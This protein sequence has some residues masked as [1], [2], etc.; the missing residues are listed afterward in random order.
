MFGS[1]PHETRICELADGR[2]LFHAAGRAYYLE[3]HAH[4]ER[5]ERQLR[6][7]VNASTLAVLA[8]FVA[9][10]WVENWWLGLFALPAFLLAVL[11]E[12][13][14]VRGLEEATDPVVRH[15]VAA[16]S[17][18]TKE[19]LGKHHFWAAVGLFF[20]VVAAVLRKRPGTPMQLLEMAVLGV[21]VAIA[22]GHLW[23]H[24]RLR[25]ER[26]II[27][28]PGRTDNTPIVPK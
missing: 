20:A 16:R 9:A 1:T 8:A 5:L 7:T 22:A 13:F 11:S 25:R 14:V 4:G 3:N 24:R 27:D 10:A 2:V 17:Q 21:T 26:E 19:A 12:F 18:A 6:W 15:E 28:G 23:R